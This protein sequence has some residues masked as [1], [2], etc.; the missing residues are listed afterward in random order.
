[1]SRS[2]ASAKHAGG[3]LRT[4][5][6]HIGAKGLAKLSRRSLELIASSSVII[7]AT[8]DDAIPSVAA[9]LAKAL[10][11]L[12]V[13]PGARS[14]RSSIAVHTSGALSSRALQ[15]LKAQGI[16][17]GSMHPLISISDKNGAGDSLSRAFF[18]LE[19]DAAAIRVGKR[20]VQDLGGRSFIIDARSKP[21]YHAA[22][23]MASPNLTALFDLALE[24]LNRCGIPNRRA[25]QILL[26]LVQSTLDNLVDQ[27]PAQALTGTFKRGDLATAKEHINAIGSAGL[28]DALCAYAVLGRHSLDLSRLPKARRIEIEQL[29]TRTLKR[30]VKGP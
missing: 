10:Q 20:V 4:T 15:P 9:D 23:V 13:A 3:L 18:S 24:M 16:S 26:P 6:E 2:A 27:E 7:V 19:G 25:R 11:S 29:L 8:P 17:I 1:M 21:L 12:Q 14:A 30:A 22:A 28:T 5:S